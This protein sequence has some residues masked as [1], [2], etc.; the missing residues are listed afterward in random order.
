MLTS[1]APWVCG[2]GQHAGL[3]GGEL[4]GPL[5]VGRVEGLVDDLRA[6]GDRGGERRVPGVA[7]DHLDVVGDGARPVRLT[8]RTVSPRLR[9]ASRVARPIAPVPKMTWRGV[10]VVMRVPRSGSCAVG[11]I[12]AGVGRQD[13]VQQ[14]S[15]QGGEGDRAVGAEDGEL[16]VHGDAADG[17]DRPAERPQRGHGGGPDPPVV[18]RGQRQGL[19]R[20]E[21]QAGQAPISAEIGQ[22]G[23]VADDGGAEEEAGAHTDAGGEHPGQ[24]VAAGEL[25]SAWPRPMTGR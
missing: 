5:G 14:Q 8:S 25:A 6:P 21:D 3:Q 12:R 10:T 13:D 23:A 11:E 17:R 20:P 18:P 4:L 19:R 1:R 24:G 2:G 22:R 7:A 15:E 9:R 16:L